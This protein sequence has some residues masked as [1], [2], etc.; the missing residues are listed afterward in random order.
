M[1]MITVTCTEAIDRSNTFTPVYQPCGNTM[2]EIHKLPNEV[3]I[4]SY[5]RE[6][7]VD[8][9]YLIYNCPS[10]NSKTVIYQKE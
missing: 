4:D 5:R 3:V 2:K 6:T 7:K 9:Y 10:C 8:G 1:P